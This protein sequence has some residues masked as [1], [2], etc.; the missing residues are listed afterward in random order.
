[1]SF[2]DSVCNNL[3]LKVRFI[4]NTLF[5]SQVPSTSQTSATQKTFNYMHLLRETAIHGDDKH[6][7]MHLLRETAIPSDD[8]H[9][10]MHLLRET[11]IPGDDEHDYMHLLRETAIPGD[12]K[13][14]WTFVIR[15]TQAGW[16][17]SNSGQW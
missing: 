12:D 10:Y 5:I 16:E 17:S 7:Y 1:M 8:E 15:W 2:T 4:S 14:R 6:D 9:D 11:A 3:N 13:H